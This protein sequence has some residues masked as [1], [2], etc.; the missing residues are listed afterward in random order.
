MSKTVNNPV[1]GWR[2]DLVR[3]RS[4]WQGAEHLKAKL[5]LF[6]LLAKSQLVLPTVEV[7]IVTDSDTWERCYKQWLQEEGLLQGEQSDLNDGEAINRAT[8]P[9]RFEIRLLDIDQS[10]HSFELE[11]LSVSQKKAR[12]REA[13]LKSAAKFI[14]QQCD[15]DDR[16]AF[17]FPPNYLFMHQQSQYDSV[18]ALYAGHNNAVDEG[19]FYDL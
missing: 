17:E 10:L 3:L 6:T 9:E 19:D 14:A 16:L 12:Y 13:W 1:I 2:L 7:C 4:F 18:L 5:E 11:S 8:L 15:A